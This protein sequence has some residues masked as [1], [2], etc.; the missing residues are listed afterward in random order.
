MENQ[1]LSQEPLS[2]GAAPETEQDLCPLC[3]QQGSR[4]EVVEESEQEVVRNEVITVKWSF[5]RCVGGCGEE[6]GR[7]EDFDPLEEALKVYRKKH[8]MVQPDELVAWREKHHLTQAQLAARL[9][10]SEKTVMRYEN[11]HLQEEAHD[12][13]IRALMAKNP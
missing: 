2:T 3:A 5:H 11:G 13:A 9:H 4:V 7:D 10:V 6:F 8:G 12:A 1:E